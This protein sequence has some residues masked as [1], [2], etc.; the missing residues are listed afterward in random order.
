MDPDPEAA[1][2]GET[3]DAELEPGHPLSRYLTKIERPRRRAGWAGTVRLVGDRRATVPVLVAGSLAALAVAIVASHGQP[4]PSIRPRAV[5]PPAPVVHAVVPLLSPAA[6][7]PV[8]LAPDPAAVPVV[9]RPSATL[10][11]PVPLRESRRAL[12]SAPAP[13]VHEPARAVLAAADL[14]DPVAVHA[15]G[16]AV[17]LHGRALRRALAVD[18]RL[19]RA[20]NEAQA[21]GSPHSVAGTQLL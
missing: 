2:P 7:P 5:R 18:R 16:P 17:P 6:G 14:D 10:P 15:A 19:T 11:W 21:G 20:A 9:S 4:G 3:P 1:V 8:A 13:R 12:T